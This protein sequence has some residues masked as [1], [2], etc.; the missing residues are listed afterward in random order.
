MKGQD[1][2][3][4]LGDFHPEMRPRLTRDIKKKKV[5]FKKATGKQLFGYCHLES[6]NILLIV[7]I[8]GSYQIS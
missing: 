3:G 6:V 1:L 7:L 4:E 5:E 8:L 2:K